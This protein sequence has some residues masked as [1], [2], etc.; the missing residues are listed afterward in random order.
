MFICEHV[1]MNKIKYSKYSKYL[2][3]FLISIMINMSMKRK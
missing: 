2:Q 1:C 3:M